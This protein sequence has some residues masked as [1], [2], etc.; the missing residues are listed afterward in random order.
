MSSFWDVLCS[1]CATKGIAPPLRLDP[2]PLTG[3]GRLVCCSHDHALLVSRLQIVVCSGQEV[4]LSYS[5]GRPS[6]S[7]TDS[8]KRSKTS[9]GQFSSRGSPPAVHPGTAVPTPPPAPAG[10]PSVQHPGGA[11]PAPAPAPA[12]L[13]SANA[14]LA[15]GHQPNPT[16]ARALTSGHKTPKHRGAKKGEGERKPKAPRPVWCPPPRSGFIRRRKALRSPSR[17]LP[18][19]TPSGLIHSWSTSLLLGPPSRPAPP[20]PWGAG[21]CWTPLSRPRW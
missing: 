16:P 11:V 4:L 20:P 19:A 21:R 9:H 12:P 1:I 18:R 8:N 5:P 10:L 6:P 13:A 7:H 14:P 15:P 17:Q 2:D 3:A